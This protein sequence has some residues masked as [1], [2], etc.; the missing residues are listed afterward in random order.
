MTFAQVS[1]P[2]LLLKPGVLCLFLHAKS[3]SSTQMIPF[4]PL[5]SSFSVPVGDLF[6][7]NILGILMS[8]MLGV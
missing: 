2:L 8:N 7:I 4:K 5:V 6:I 1:R 3:K